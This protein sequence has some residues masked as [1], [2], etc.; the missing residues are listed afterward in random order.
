MRANVRIPRRHR[1]D[2]A[3]TVW[4]FAGLLLRGFLCVAVVAGV[5]GREPERD[6]EGSF[7]TDDG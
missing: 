5:G 6:F 2:C 1:A 3:Q 7:R 4:S